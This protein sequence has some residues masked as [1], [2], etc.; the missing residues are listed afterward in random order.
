[1]IITRTPSRLPLGGGGTDLSSYYSRF[2]GFFVSAAIDK[3]NYIAVKPR[4]ENGFRIS[5]SKTEI[6]DKI[7]DV[8]QPIIREALNLVG[9]Q[10]S[11]EI[12][13]M[14]DVPGRSGLGG[15]SGY[16][17][18]ALNALHAYQRDHVTQEKLA[19]EACHIEIDRLREPIGKQD[20]YVAAF[21]GINSYE[22]ELDGTVR[23]RSLAISSHVEAELESGILLFY[24]GITRDASEILRGI[25]KDEDSDSRRVIETMHKIKELGYQIRDA[26]LAGD[27]L[28]FAELLDVHWQTK[29]NLSVNVSNGRI[30]ALYETA[31]LNG[32]IGGK[33]MGAGGGG[34]F[35][36]YSE[37]G[38]RKKLREAMTGQGMREVRFR[39]EHEGSKILLNL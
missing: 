20:Q 23:T 5:Y 13:S 16:C 8:Q 22:I 3:F 31:K 6:V 33:I 1:L 35:M 19:Q 21:G 34:F 32:A 4:F 15:S 28:R 18:G 11:L 7:E 29:K 25:K 14:A 10:D 36:F 26:L 9:V 30:D 17:V 27:I 37:P 12:V 24:T 39:F 2:G 38:K